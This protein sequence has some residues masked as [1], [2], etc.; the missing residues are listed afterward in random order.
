M[1]VALQLVAVAATPLNFTVLVPCVAPKFVPVIMTGVPGRPEAGFKLAIVGAAVVT[2]YMTPLLGSPPTL[3]ITLPVVAPDGTVATMLVALQLVTVAA[4]PLNVT[5]LVPCA[6]PK[7]VPV[8]VTWVPTGPE[9][10]FRLVI[11]AS[12]KTTKLNP[13]LEWPLALTT[14]LPV[15]APEGTFAEMLV[16]LQLLVDATVPLKLTVLVPCVLPKFVPVITTT[17]PTWAEDGVMLAM[18]RFAPLLLV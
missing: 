13:L 14:T 15:V 6:A 16:M 17:L 12:G 10:G 2:V 18:F 11:D 1:L 5:V 3:T 9:L 4:T 8:I 7:F